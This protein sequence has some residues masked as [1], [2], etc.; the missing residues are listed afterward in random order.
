MERA[1]CVALGNL[2][3]PEFAAGASGHN[4]LFRPARNPYDNAR[5]LGGS[6]TNAAAAVA[7]RMIPF[8]IGTDTAGSVRIRAAL[9]GIVGYNLTNASPAISTAQKY[10]T[11]SGQGFTFRPTIT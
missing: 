11:V 5:T 2:N 9:R 4:P 6:S 7:S 3:T 10:N 1:G 8:A